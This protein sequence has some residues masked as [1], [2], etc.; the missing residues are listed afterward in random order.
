MDTH[1]QTVVDQFS[2]QVN[3]FVSSPHVNAYEPVDRF[4]RLLD[5]NEEDQV[6]DVGCGPGLLAKYFAPRVKHFTGVDMTPAMVNKAKDLAILDGT[7]NSDFHVAD[8]TDL[9]FHKNAFDMVITRLALHHIPDTEKAIREMVR[10]LKPGG[11]LGV[12]DMITSE[13]VDEA[14]LHNKFERLRDPSHARTLSLSELV[15]G[16]ECAGVEIVSIDIMN[17]RFDL[18]DYFDRAEQSKE[19]QDAAR[20][21]ISHEY[22]RQSFL[23]RRISKNETAYSYSA[24]W[25]MLAAR[26]HDVVGR[27]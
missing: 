1:A 23:G 14:V 3:R 24:K 17:Y 8:A 26:K 13:I 4:L 12:Y 18:D 25:C 6:L 9:N 27:A 5:P 10:V 11:T 22:G 19:S 16:V 7:G 2:A 20:E 15:Y 21:I